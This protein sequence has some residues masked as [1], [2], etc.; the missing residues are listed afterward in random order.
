MQ[1][2]IRLRVLVLLCSLALAGG[3]TASHARSAVSPLAAKSCLSGGSCP[4]ACERVRVLVR[5]GHTTAEAL[6]TAL[7]VTAGALR[8]AAAPQAR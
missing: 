5:A 1:P 3:A 6:G 7:R 8:R 4:R 2:N